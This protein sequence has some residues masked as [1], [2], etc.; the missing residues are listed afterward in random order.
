MDV[1]APYSYRGQKLDL[2]QLELQTI[3]SCHVGVG[4]CLEELP[5]LLTT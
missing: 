5:V 2:L 1:C 4:E 3:V